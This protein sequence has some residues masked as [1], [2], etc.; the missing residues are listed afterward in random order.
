MTNEQLCIQAKSGNQQALNQLVIQNQRF[1]HK[2]AYEVWNAQ[3][4][5]NYSL[6][7]EIDDLAQEDMLGLIAFAEKFQADMGHKFLTYAVLTI[8][9]AIKKECIC[10]IALVLRITRS[11]RSPKR[12]GTSIYRRAVPR[13]PNQMH[14][15]MFVVIWVAT[16]VAGRGI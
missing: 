2:V 13:K 6:G 8:R 7:I 11:I 15:T 14:W 12:H 4:E 16:A 10:G 9:N 5:L 1:I 3:K